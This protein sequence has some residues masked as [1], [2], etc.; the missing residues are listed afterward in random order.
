MAVKKCSDCGGKVSSSAKACPHCGAKVKKS[1]GIVGW[2]F[3]I[4]IVLPTAWTIG[5]AINR[6]QNEALYTPAASDSMEEAE[7]N[8]AAG[9]ARDSCK[10]ISDY[11][12]SAMEAR[13]KG[14]VMSDLPTEG[15]PVLERIV[16]GAYEQGRYMTESLVERK[17]VDYQNDVYLKC[18]KGAL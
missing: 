14:V 11:A 8:P 10:Q 17:I 18:I 9:D 1:V 7:R 15:N 12:R 4:F 16:M 2:L 13:Q 3:I 5:K 6:D